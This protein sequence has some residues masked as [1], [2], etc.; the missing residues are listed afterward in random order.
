MY[1]TKRIH[2]Y[3][4]ILLLVRTAL[5]WSISKWILLYLMWTSLSPCHPM[6][7]QLFTFIISTLGEIAFIKVVGACILCGK[8]SWF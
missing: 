7:G 1:G 4:Y 5:R 6:T 3:F 2:N 8:L